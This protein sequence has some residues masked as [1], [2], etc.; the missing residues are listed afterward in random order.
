MKLY[1]ILDGNRKEK[2]FSC[3]YVWTNILNGKHYVGQTQ[4]FYNRMT[5]YDRVGATQYLQ[6]AINKYGVDCFNIEILEL[7]DVDNL[8]GREQ[9]WMDFYESYMPDKGYNI[10]HYAS[11][12]RGYKHTEE[13]RKK[14]SNIV[15]LNAAHLFGENNPMYGKVHPDE[16]RKKHSEW[17]KD[18]WANDEEYRKFWSEK[19]SGENNYFYGKH[20]D[21]E[22][23]PRWGKHCNEE[24]KQKARDHHPFTIKVICVETNEEFESINQAVRYFGG[25]AANVSAVLDK[26]NRM[27]KGYHFIRKNK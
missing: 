11:T 17:L 21:G 15:K 23:N 5:Q 22:S 14:I 8:D 2:S 4:N 1:E 13:T 19:M 24:S 27:Y 10:C 7:C 3:I 6:I 12:T 18:R 20:F 9:F 26:P 16:W 25:K